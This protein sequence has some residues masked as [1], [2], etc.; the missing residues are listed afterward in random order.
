[1][2]KLAKIEGKEK[3]LRQIA[4][5]ALSGNL[6]S[7]SKEL[8][9]LC[10]LDESRTEFLGFKQVDYLRPDQQRLFYCG[11]AEGDG[12]LLSS[13]QKTVLHRRK[14]MLQEPLILA[15]FRGSS[16]VAHVKANCRRAI[17]HPAVLEK[18]A[19]I[20]IAEE[21]KAVQ[22][23]VAALFKDSEIHDDAEGCGVE[24]FL[25]FP[26]PNSAEQFYPRA[27]E[28]RRQGASASGCCAGCRGFDR[29]LPLCREGTGPERRPSWETSGP[30]ASKSP[31]A[32]PRYPVCATGRQ[33]HETGSSYFCTPC[34]SGLS[35]ACS[36]GTPCRSGS[37]PSSSQCCH[38]L[39]TGSGGSSWSLAR[40]ISCG[41]HGMR[42]SRVSPSAPGRG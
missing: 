6:A 11:H 4:C 38:S 16:V 12:E 15:L 17:M 13:T 32:Q 21:G 3:C 23:A 41:G 25:P 42:S 5:V 26:V 34:S 14:T 40:P 27:A 39:S 36:A 28:R 2:R 37:A 19:V 20:G 10:R 31:Q 24:F 18:G 7:A 8:P 22:N 33:T 35:R 30:P 1:M 9:G 29:L